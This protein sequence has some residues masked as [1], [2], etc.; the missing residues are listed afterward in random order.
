MS[1]KNDLKKQDSILE[2]IHYENKNTLYFLDSTK[3]LP[4][5]KHQI[6]KPH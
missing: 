3:N 5:K 2:R 6:Q 1:L 4:F